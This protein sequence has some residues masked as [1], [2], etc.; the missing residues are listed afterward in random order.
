[1]VEVGD[2]V[3]RDDVLE[4]REKVADNEVKLHSLTS[5]NA[6]ILK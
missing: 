4:L 3:T 5:T 2:L 6:Q 1:M